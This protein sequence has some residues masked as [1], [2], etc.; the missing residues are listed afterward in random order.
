MSS[1]VHAFSQARLPALA[2]FMSASANARWPAMTP[3]LPG[4]LAWQL[5]GSNARQNLKLWYRQGRL[6][7][8]AW[9]QPPC[10]LLF[11]ISDEV[12]ARGEI[13]IEMLEWACTRQLQ[14]EPGYPFYLDL[15]SMDEWA[16]AIRAGPPETAN[17][18]RFLVTS[19]LDSN[20]EMVDVV[21]AAG[22]LKSEYFEPH[23]AVS[24]QSLSPLPAASAY[25]IRPV[26]DT[27]LEARVEVH[28]AAWAPSSGFSMERYLQVR[29]LTQIY[30]PGLDL[31]AVDPGGNF[32]SSC[33]CWAD[34]ETGIGFFEPFG[35]R[36]EARGTGVSQALILAGLHK[37]RE[38]GMTHGRIYTAGFNH[39]ARRLYESCGFELKEYSRTYVK[40]IA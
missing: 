34:P 14:F 30:D 31:V 28:R 11:D 23:L 38:L 17:T 25:T 33:I 13:A 15:Q 10:N 16:A 6:I 37:L 3:M 12:S 29:S 4:D 20:R 1:S 21:D 35:T 40:Q 36:P 5:P 8:Y 22:F 24:L 39:A 7:G 19:V 9:F 18:E 2:D 32:L 27:E 26:T